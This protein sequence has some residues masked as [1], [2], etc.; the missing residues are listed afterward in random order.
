MLNERDNG[1]YVCINGLYLKNNKKYLIRIC[2]ILIQ[3]INHLSL[4]RNTYKC[5]Y[6]LIYYINFTNC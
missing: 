2:N 5:L 6:S 3:T 1:L 4:K